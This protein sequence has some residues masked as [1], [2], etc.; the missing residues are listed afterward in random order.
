MHKRKDSRVEFDSPKWCYEIRA[1]HVADEP[2]G[3]AAY[4]AKRAS[5][6]R[7]KL[8]KNPSG[9]DP[10]TKPNQ[11]CEQSA[12]H[13]PPCPVSRKCSGE[14]EHED[15]AGLCDGQAAAQRACEAH[16]ET[17]ATIYSQAEFD[18][19]KKA[20][21]EG[22]GDG[23]A[24]DGSKAGQHHWIGGYIGDDD[25]GG[26]DSCSTTAGMFAYWKEKDVDGNQVRRNQPAAALRGPRLN[27]CH[28][29]DSGVHHRRRRQR[30]SVDGSVQSAGLPR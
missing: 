5:D 28:L 13:L 8:C 29:P 6:G 12:D 7:F 30:R 9:F 17:L 16:K 20:M 3:C 10:A 14:D 22:E 23:K 19:V 26:D 4:Y 2:E 25:A 15:G 27:A 18:A 1:K 11:K 24:D 21:G